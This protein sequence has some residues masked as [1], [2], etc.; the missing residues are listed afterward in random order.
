MLEPLNASLSTGEG[1]GVRP[2]GYTNLKTALK[3]I[4][5]VTPSGANYLYRATKSDLLLR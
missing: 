3:S 1:L 5:P 2:N 4:E